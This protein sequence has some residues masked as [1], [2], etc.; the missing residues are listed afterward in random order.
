MKRITNIIRVLTIL[1]LTFLI[2]PI[3]AKA[4]SSVRRI[5][6]IV[7]FAQFSQEESYN[8]MDAERTELLV[9]GL[10]QKDTVNSMY[11]YIDAI[12]YGQAQTACYFPQ[13]D[14]DTIQPY[15][16][17]QQLENYTRSSLALEIIKNIDIPED[18]PLD[19][20][21]DGYVDN[22][23]L[24]IDGEAKSQQDTLWP[25]MSSLAYANLT[26]NGKTV[27]SYNIHNSTRLFNYSM[28]E[29]VSMSVLCHEFLHSLGYPDLYH[30][31]E[32]QL[33]GVPAMWDI[34]AGYSSSLVYPL[35]YMRASRS[36]WLETTDITEDGTY[37]L[38]PA[39][40]SNG[41][42]VYLLK[43]SLS[44]TEF[45]AVEFR[46]HGKW[47]ELDFSCDT[48]MVIYRVNT[49]VE[50]NRNS[51]TDEIYVFTPYG[52]IGSGN[53]GGEGEDNFIGSLNPE[54]GI[55]NGALTYSNGMN[56]GI[57]IEN[58]TIDGDTLTFDVQFAEID[59]Q[60][61]WIA[62][63]NDIETESTLK[64]LDIAVS[65]S[66]T[67]YLAGMKNA[68]SVELYRVSETSCELVS[69]FSSAGS[70]YEIQLAVAGETPYLLYRDKDYRAVLCSYDIASGEW[71]TL[72]ENKELTQYTD[73]TVKGEDVYICYT[74][75]ESCSL[76]A[77]C[78]T[79]GK[80]TELGD[81][82]SKKAYSV[83]IVCTNE[84]VA[85]AYRDFTDHSLPK[86][87]LWEEDNW[88]NITLSD[89]SCGGVSAAAD[90][91]VITVAT[92]P[93]LGETAGVYQYQDGTVTFI[94]YPELSGYPF[95][96]QP[97]YIN[98]TLITAICTQL[99]FNYSLYCYND[100]W[101]RLGN[102]LEAQYILYPCVA[103][104]GNRIY[105]AYQLGMG[106][107]DSNP[108]LIKTLQ[109]GKDI[110]GDVNADGKFNVIDV[111][112]L[113]KWLLA[114]P[115]AKLSDWKAADFDKNNRL[116]AFDLCLMKYAL[117]EQ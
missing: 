86:L 81:T 32:L 94:E 9:N 96:V 83:S 26:I 68:E 100:G 92:I 91:K 31:N 102:C 35:A 72:W 79:D 85:V 41:N 107:T 73:I 29:P 42:R 103:V 10:T 55:E 28:F 36:G 90:G 22:F 117:L 46:Q 4:E 54:D 7:L 56:S 61:Q 2:L 62:V 59:R 80:I 111:I 52:K 109:Y 53:Y 8:F 23:I 75:G 15:V 27:D 6:N 39:S 99:D 21:N 11:G 108:V 18:I 95:Y 78:Y 69:E 60:N 88:T 106:K 50:G 104:S 17:S 77:I 64:T 13:M 101:E 67:V 37:T 16:L 34:M 19:G 98:G 76:Y 12:S 116:N 74:N 14:G 113:Q 5:N 87:A 30:K 97:A 44:D 110:A 114:V 84:T 45:F 20:D 93:S 3:P 33:D 70:M 57:R 105:T 25:H 58:I 49:T 65:E 43:T 82:I 47:G 115:D 40:A 1:C 66:G 38:A 51:N 24:V 63:P 112:L 89:T 71:K 48:G